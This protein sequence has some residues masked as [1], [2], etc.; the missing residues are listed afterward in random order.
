M[1]VM[2]STASVSQ[3]TTIYLVGSLGRAV[4][5]TK[6]ELDVHSTAEAIKAIN[7]ITR[8]K[9]EQYLAGPA[10]NKLYRIALQRRNNVIDPKEAVNR[11]G[12]STIYI[13]PT[14]RGR[15]SGWGKVIAGIALI[16]L[17]VYTGGLGAAAG[18]WAFGAPA[19]AGAAQGLTLLGSMAVGFGVSLLLGGITQLLTPTPKGPGEAAEQ[20]GSTTFQGNATAVVQGGCVPLVYGRALVSPIPVSISVNNNDVS[21]TDAGTDGSV[22]DD[23]LEGGGHQY[24]PPLNPDEQD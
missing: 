8:G 1:S 7:V 6:L 24:Q 4:G 11:S 5:H 15:N 14:I 23:E 20:K 17:T 19:A 21:T 22:E 3:L 12:R 10:R 16:A 9:L 2:T 13:M 18:G